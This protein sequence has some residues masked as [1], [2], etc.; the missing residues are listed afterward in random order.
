MTIAWGHLAQ[1]LSDHDEAFTQAVAEY[2][3]KNPTDKRAP[4]QMDTSTFRAIL[5]RA[6]EI[7]VNKQNEP[8]GAEQVWGGLPDHKETI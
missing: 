2:R 4:C 8:Q 3:E 7:R 1:P 6:E 5:K